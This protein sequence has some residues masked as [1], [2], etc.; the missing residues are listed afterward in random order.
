MD[1]DTLVGRLPSDERSDDTAGATQGFIAVSSSG[2]TAASP[3]LAAVLTAIGAESPGFAGHGAIHSASWGL[4]ELQREQPLLLTRTARRREQELGPQDVR[5]LLTGPAHDG[6]AEVLPTFAAVDLVDDDTLVAAADVLGFRHL[7]Y[8]EGP[9]FAVLSTSARGVAACLG[10]GLDREAIAVQ[11][12]LGWQVGQRT[13][14]DGVQKLAPGE[15]ATLRDGRISLSSFRRALD[16]SPRDL[17]A[18]VDEAAQVLRDYLH[19]FLDDHP[20]AV[21]QLTGGQ[22]RACC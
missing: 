3:Q 10:T 8:G 2:P 12:L 20:G 15:L 18:S 17:D 9:G 5:R 6:L 4:P 22:V 7:Y 11:S 19:A 13:L 21:M 16:P 14:F 1:I